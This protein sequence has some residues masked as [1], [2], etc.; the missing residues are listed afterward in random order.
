M[1]I[2]KSERLTLLKCRTYLY[3]SLIYS[4]NIIN[5]RCTVWLWDTVSVLM[6]LDL[7]AAFDSIDHI[8]L[9]RWLQTTYGLNGAIIN[10]FTSCLSSRLQHVR[11]STTSSAPSA[12]PFVHASLGCGRFVVFIDL[13]IN[14]PCWPWFAPLW[15]ARST[16]AFLHSPAPLAT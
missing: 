4:S 1:Y 16:I 2:C 5:Q 15:S 10:W 7:S 13:F 9:L 12:V 6:L 8:M 3:T 11:I 14:T